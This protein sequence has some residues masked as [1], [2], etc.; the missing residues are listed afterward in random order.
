MCSARRGEDAAE[1]IRDGADWADG[2]AVYL[3]RLAPFA[4]YG[5][6]NRSENSMGYLRAQDAYALPPGDWQTEVVAIRQVLQDLGYVLPPRDQ[7]IERLPIKL[8]IPTVLEDK[9][10]F[11]AIYYGED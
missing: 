8:D 1:F 7:L 9:H 10:V 6:E 5:R 2:I 4:V 11:D 3:S